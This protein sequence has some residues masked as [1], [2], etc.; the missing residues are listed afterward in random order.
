MRLAHT[1]TFFLLFCLSS[2]LISPIHSN[3][4]ERSEPQ[5]VRVSYAQGE[6]KFST[7]KHGQPDLGNDWMKAPEGLI[8]EE[9]YTLATEDGRAVVEF[10]NGSMAYLAEHSVLQFNKLQIKAGVTTTKLYLLTGTAA[11]AHVSKGQDQMAIHTPTAKVISKRAFGLRIDSTLNGT[12]VRALDTQVQLDEAT[13]REKWNLKPGETVVYLEGFRF[14]LK[15][16]MGHP[17]SDAWDKWVDAQRLAHAAEIKKGLEESGLKEPIPGLAD[18]V[19]NGRFFDCPP[20]GKCWEPT[21]QLGV[22]ELTATQGPTGSTGAAV[23]TIGPRNFVINRALIS[24]CPMETWMYSVGRPSRPGLLA[25]NEPEETFTISS[26]PWTSCFAGSWLVNGCWA[27][28]GLTRYCRHGLVYVVGPPHRKHPIWIVHTP[29]GLGVVPRH[30]L[31]HNG[32]P[33]INAKNGVFLL[34]REKDEIQARFEPL[35]AKGLHWETSLPKEFS[36]DRILMANATK[37]TPPVIEGSVLRLAYDRGPITL[38]TSKQDENEIRY[39]YKTR[40][41][42]AT[43]TIGNGAGRI[44]QGQ[45]MVMAH[46]GSHGASGG[47]TGHG[48]GWF[49]GSGGGSSAG[50][51]G[52]GSSGGGGGHASGGSSSSGS[53]GSASAGAGGGGHH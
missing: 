16:L 37:I 44:S 11:F 35:P 50:H 33:P 29:H 23:A 27:A 32:R 48:G 19:K 31:D 26:F 41:F 42:V 47:V 22:E 5:L 39:D 14:P 52:G 21:P 25:A 17:E 3:S 18:L 1:R 46:V 45:P 4:Q 10:E 30:P 40:N 34:A 2:S 49:G 13:Q 6:V 15:G 28:G 12:I 7:G 43:R 38:E 24:R 36:P 20:Y 9:G 8:L 51:G 53:S